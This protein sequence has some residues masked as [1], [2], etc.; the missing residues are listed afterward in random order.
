MKRRAAV[1]VALPA[2]VAL[3]VVRPASADTG[4]GT[5]GITA[6]AAAARTA[7]DAGAGGGLATLDSGSAYV[8]ASLDSAPSS[9]VLAAPVEPGSLVRT[10]VG[11]VNGNLGDQVVV[12]PAAEAQSPGGSGDAELTTAPPVSA[13]PLST[14]GGSATAKAS[15][16]ASSGSATGS[17]LTVTGVVTVEGAV[18]EADLRADVAGGRL[19]A[20]VRSAV[21]RV[22]V[23]GVLELRDVVAT[24]SVRTDGSRHV[25]AAQLTVGGATVAGVP[26]SV[27]SD[28]VTALVPLVPGGTLAQATQAANDALAGSGVSVRAFDAVVRADGTSAVA[29]A[30]GVQVSVVTPALPGGVPGNALDLVLGGAA[31]TESAL[32]ATPDAPPVTGPVS[33]GPPATGGGPE[34]VVVPG[35]PGTPGTPAVPGQPAVPPPAVAPSRP[36]SL[37]VA[38]KELSAATVVAGF[39]LWQ[40]LTVGN[41]T[42]FA[43]TDRR[44][45]D[46]EEDEQ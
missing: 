43:L 27:G 45:K 8:S 4:Y 10:G 30:G 37:S 39:G 13:G 18:S 22:V 33:G 25:P 17:D 21:G 36:A 15:A 32:P 29:D 42:L 12:V 20:S 19:Q 23:A 16:T 34:V 6:L 28:G 9:R 41:V 46:D 11:Q 35:T 38:G 3:A 5:F 2:V 26:V 31:I 14:R 7:G 24:A 44:R 1:L 40:L